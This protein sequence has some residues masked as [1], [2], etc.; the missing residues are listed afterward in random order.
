V[1]RASTPTKATNFDLAPSSHM[2]TNE[3]QSNLHQQRLGVCEHSS[4][5]GM[6]FPASLA[7]KSCACDP[8]IYCWTRRT[9]T[10]TMRLYTSRI[11]SNR[12]VYT[13]REIA[14]RQSGSQ[15]SSPAT[16]THAQP[17]STISPY[18]TSPI[19]R[20]DGSLATFSF[21]AIISSTSQAAHT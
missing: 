7:A 14:N 3:V 1:A 8:R 5:Y 10:R 6:R 13:T 17:P 12:P 16:S 21:M 4:F 18:L 11:F 19:V 9:K 15:N 2:R 20:R